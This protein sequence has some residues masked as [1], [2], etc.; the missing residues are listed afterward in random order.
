MNT[1]LILFDG[2]C[3]FCNYWVDFIIQRDQK[4]FFRFVPIQSRFARN[5]T[6]ELKIDASKSD[7]II[8]LVN[9]KVYFKSDAVMQITKKLDGLWKLLYVFMIIP[10]PI[11][12]LIY[13]LFAKNRYN[14]FGRKKSCRIPSKFEESRFISEF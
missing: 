8:L 3:N 14:W 12:D 5:L 1:G 7:T 10:K 2:V 11:R 6:A 9:E 13:N 4:A